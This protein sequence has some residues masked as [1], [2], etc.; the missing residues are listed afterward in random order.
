LPSADLL[1]PGGNLKQ[2]KNY[3]VLFLMAGI[4]ISLDQWTK[5]LVR[6]NLPEGA[7]WLPAGMAWLSPYARIVHSSNTGAAFGSFQGH[8]G[9]IFTVVAVLVS[10]V[11]LYYYSHT[12]EVDWWMRLAMGLLLGGALGNN[13][14]DRVLIGRV[15]DFISVG[16]FWVFNIADM[17][18]NVCVAVMLLGLWFK[19]RSEQKMAGAQPDLLE[20]A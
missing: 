9:W 11:V 6:A 14:F 1:L 13:L 15:T 8:N 16:N 18:L 3:V 4:I 2:I 17:S 7:T 19:R 20:E 10:A 12:P 5:Y